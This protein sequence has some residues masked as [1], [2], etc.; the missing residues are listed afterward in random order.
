MLHPSTI[1]SES[2][3][4]SQYIL[5][6]STATATATAS[7]SLS[8][9]AVGPSTGVSPISTGVPGVDHTD[10]EF[11]NTGGTTENVEDLDSRMENQQYG[12]YEPNYGQIPPD[13]FGVG[14]AMALT[15]NRTTENRLPLTTL[16]E[17]EHI[18]Q[19][20][21][22]TEFEIA[23]TSAPDLLLTPS[24]NVSTT[25]GQSGPAP[26]I[27][28]DALTHALNMAERT[29]QPRGRVPVTTPAPGVQPR[30]EA[31]SRQESGGNAD[32]EARSRQESGDNADRGARSRQQSGGNVDRGRRR[33]Q[34][35]RGDVAFAAE[36]Y[37]KDMLEIQRQRH[38]MVCYH[39][40]VLIYNANRR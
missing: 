22:T 8:A 15:Q 14:V 21:D 27:T 38:Y 18:Q 32:R 24:T 12:E 13:D 4:P 25:P 28:R 23:T 36:K 1:T 3:H 33:I 40:Y 11:A 17:E 30:Q 35:A 20:M 37:Y 2:D 9:P 29:L 16:T 34:A 10:T 19:V 5:P 31:R 39:N 26:F 7:S 6:C